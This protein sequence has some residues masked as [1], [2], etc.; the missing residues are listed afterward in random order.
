MSADVLLLNSTFEPLGV[1][2]LERAVRL[3]F[4]RKAEVIHDDGRLVRSESLSF[5]LPLVVRLLYYVTHRRKKVALTKKNVLLRD[6]YR[7]AYCSI[8]GAGEMTVDHVIPRS[9]GG[10]STWENLVAS[11]STC[12]G[13]K[14]DRTPDE[15]RMPLT[16]RPREPRF[17]PWIV[18]KRNTVPGEWAKYLT[19][20]SV[21]IE[22]RVG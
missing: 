12:N 6:D 4:Q 15:A 17:I 22:E 8:R 7:C 13:R 21:G 16:K 14:R 18:V 19:L 10:R 11:C 20:Y 9:R 2:R 5:P 1:V 3:L